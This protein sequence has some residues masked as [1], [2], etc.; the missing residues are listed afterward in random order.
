MAKILLVSNKDNN[1]Y[2]FRSELILKLIELNHEVLLMCPYGRKIDFFTS[3]GCH[4]IDVDVDRRGTRLLTDLR[5]L[6]KY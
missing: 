4:F 5:L 1:F 3:R 6:L 2:N